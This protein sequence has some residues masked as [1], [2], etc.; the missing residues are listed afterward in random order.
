MKMIYDNYR[1]LP[2]PDSQ[3]PYI[4]PS[5]GNHLGVTMPKA[6]CRGFRY[7]Y[8]GYNKSTR[9]LRF[10]CMSMKNGRPADISHRCLAKLQVNL[11]SWN[12]SFYNAHICT[13]ADDLD[14]SKEESM[15]EIQARLDR[16]D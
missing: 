7:N 3:A 13:Y 6:Y 10:H 15:K 8:L 1:F 14:Q 12:F 2:A 11:D 5:R 16:D 9:E 4:Y